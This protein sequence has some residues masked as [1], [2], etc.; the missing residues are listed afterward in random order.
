MDGIRGETAVHSAAA[1]VER[2][3]RVVGVTVLDACGDVVGNHP[4][5]AG[6]GRPAPKGLFVATGSRAQL[7]LGSGETGGAVKKE[8]VE[9]DA[10]AGAKRAVEA[11]VGGDPAGRIVAPR[12]EDIALG[13]DDKIAPLP[14]GPGITADIESIGI[15]IADSI[16]VGSRPAEPPRTP[17]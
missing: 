10:G 3:V 17:R 6:A 5:D 12:K 13:A 2:L 1:E 15:D 4:F 11:L 9:R 14:V 7:K 16:G 8:A